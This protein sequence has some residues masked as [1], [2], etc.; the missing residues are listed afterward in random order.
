MT[1]FITEGEIMGCLEHVNIHG[2]ENVFYIYPVIGPA[3]VRCV[4]PVELLTDVSK[5]VSKKGTRVIV[6]G[7]LK[8]E[9]QKTYPYEVVVKKI[10][11]IKEDDLPKLRDLVGL[12]TDITGGLSS[13]EFIRKIRENDD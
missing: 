3:S 7:S 4:F 2:Q 11:I 10:R 6:S 5:A 13:E 12:A 9:K 8:Y 1:N